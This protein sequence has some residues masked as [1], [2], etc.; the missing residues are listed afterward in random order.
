MQEGMIGGDMK[1]GG[2]EVGLGLQERE[3]ES[4]LF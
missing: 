3:P 2:S 4:V 1:V